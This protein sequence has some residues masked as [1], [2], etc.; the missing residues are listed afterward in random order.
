MS[1]NESADV[2]RARTTLSARS[3]IA[4]TLLGTH[5]PELPGR[6]LIALATR[7]GVSE[8]TTRVAL[9]RMVEK[10]ELTNVEGT[11]AL[12]GP[13]KARQLRLDASRIGDEVAWSGRWVQAV[14][15]AKGASA[16]QR[17]QRRSD[18]LALKLGELR[19]G[20]WLRPDNLDPQ[21]LPA[22]VAR[23]A[24]HVMWA[25]MSPLDAHPEL[26]AQLW[27]LAGWAATAAELQSALETSVD[28]LS[29]N[30]PR[31]LPTGFEVSAAVLRHFVADPALPSRLL[32]EDWPGA[33]LR[34]RYDSFDDLYRAA[35]RKFFA[36]G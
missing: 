1:G 8:G 5:P 3:L 4:S 34:R 6:L 13:L 15:V 25:S 16:T 32:G 29:S 14:I 11:Y 30:D 31:A 23:L 35:L 27:D 22:E 21:R 17:S 28:L 18:L 20:V 33:E 9:S 26:V 36:E 2:V 7:F 12:A 19:E 10:G 24:P